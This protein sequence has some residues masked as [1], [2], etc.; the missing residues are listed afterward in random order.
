MYDN[1]L[2]SRDNN[3]ALQLYAKIHEIGI[4]PQLDREPS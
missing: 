4:A 2:A 1:E 3:A